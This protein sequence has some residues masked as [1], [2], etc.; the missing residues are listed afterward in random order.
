MRKNFLSS[1]ANPTKQNQSETGETRRGGKPEPNTKTR[2][3]ATRSTESGN[4]HKKR[5]AR[6]EGVR[7]T[8]GRTKPQ[9]RGNA[10]SEQ[11]ER[12]GKNCGR[13]REKKARRRRREEEDAVEPGGIAT[14][15]AKNC[16]QVISAG[17]IRRQSRALGTRSVAPWESPLPEGYRRSVPLFQDRG[18]FQSLLM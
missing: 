7:A 12:K 11:K 2:R 6:R 14:A 18:T 9:E 17:Y 13:E 8:R 4:P 16:S 10:T 1:S 5:N 15:R 3:G